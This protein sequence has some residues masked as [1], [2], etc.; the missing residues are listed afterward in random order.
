MT[1]LTEAAEKIVQYIDSRHPIIIWGDFDVDGITATSLLLEFFK[2]LQH[3]VEWHI[4]KRIAEGYGLNPEVFKKK[5]RHVLN[6]M[7]LVITV[8]CGISNYNE[9]IEL[10]R[11]GGEVIITDHHQLPSGKLPE[12]IIVNPQQKNC[13]FHHENLSGVGIAFYLAVSLRNMLDKKKYFK[14]GFKPNLKELLSYV[15]LGSLADLVPYSETNRILVRSGLESLQNTKQPG[16][17][18]FLESSG[19]ADSILTSEDIGFILGPKI[20]AAG[21]LEKGHLA[22]EL[23]TQRDGSGGAVELSRKILQFN[24]KRKKLCDREFQLAAEEARKNNFSEHFVLVTGKFH[25]GVA[26]IVASRL[27]ESFNK[28]A[29]VLC[30]EYLTDEKLQLRGSARSVSGI[31]LVEC[32]H[33]CSEFLTRYGGHALAAGLQ[34][35]G[36][37]IEKF[38]Q[39]FALRITQQAM[40]NRETIQENS[41][42]YKYTP[43]EIFQN[44]TLEKLYLL[45]PHMP[46]NEKPV[47]FFDTDDG[48]LYS[49]LFGGEGEHLQILLRGKK[50]NFRGVGFNLGDKIDLLKKDAHCRIFFSPMLNRYQ[51]MLNW[52]LRIVDIQ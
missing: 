3:D 20:N 8:D 37:N 48:I 43:D 28:T 12:C 27:V 7:F 46:G 2:L 24:E 15:A 50:Q 23:L 22:V 34:L 10:Q 40:L 31:N 25:P 11:I 30:E 13:G 4:P 19:L 49:R 29:I 38:R 32:L 18:I 47:F 14:N 5:F 1:G 41:S 44:E 52:Q 6:E 42:S 9:I 45:E 16:V 26:G 35:E 33:G 39:K 51:G 36:R 21:R 17:R